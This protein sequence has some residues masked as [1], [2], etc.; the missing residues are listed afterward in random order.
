MTRKWNHCKKNNAIINKS[1]LLELYNA[2]LNK[3]NN[4]TIKSNSKLE[5]ITVIEKHQEPRKKMILFRHKLE[6]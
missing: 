3:I 1:L 4:L 5:L 2:I 6:H